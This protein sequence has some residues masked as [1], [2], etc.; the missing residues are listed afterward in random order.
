MAFDIEKR[1][2]LNQRQISPLIE[3][4]KD[5]KVYGRNVAMRPQNFFQGQI[6][7]NLK[8]LTLITKQ[9]V[10]CMCVCT[11]ACMCV[12]MCVCVCVCVNVH[13][14]VH[15]SKISLSIPQLHNKTGC[16][17]IFQIL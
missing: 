10:K 12:Y 16:D 6:Y 1:F 9:I 14:C 7:F 17:R 4:G 8:K 11:C 13:A 3:I 5:P 2:F 15:A